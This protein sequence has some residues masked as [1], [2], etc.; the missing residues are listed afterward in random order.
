V[1]VNGVLFRTGP[2]Q[3]IPTFGER[4]E[5][6]IVSSKLQPTAGRHV[7]VHRLRDVLDLPGMRRVRQG[8]RLGDWG[9]GAASG[10]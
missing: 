6:F 2:A 1:E 10:E 5:H 8:R 9:K 4:E 3:I 7:A